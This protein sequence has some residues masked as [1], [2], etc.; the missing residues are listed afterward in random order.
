MLEIWTTNKIKEGFER[1]MEENGRLPSAVEIDVIEYLPSSRLIQRKFGGLEQ[2]RGQFGYCDTHF[3][4]GKFRSSIAFRVGSRG[5]AEELSLEKVLRQHFGEVFVHTEKMFDTSKN[6]VDFFVYSPAGNFGV[7]VFYTESMHCLQSNINI[8]MKKY[9]AFTLELL[10]V[11]ANSKFKQSDLDSY[12]AAKI[13]PLPQTMKLI[14]M[15]TL[16]TY[17]QTRQ[18]YR[19]PLK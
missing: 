14:T 2:L 3:G 8:K 11:V 19:D 10:L 9:H 4:K 5:R 13:K 16:L 7:D 18:A 6:R 15:K 17:I 12:A 1:F